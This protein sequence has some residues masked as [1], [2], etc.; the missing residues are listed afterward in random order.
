MIL[1][2]PRTRP[3]FPLV[4]LLFVACSRGGCGG[5]GTGNGV[6]AIRFLSAEERDPRPL[7]GLLGATFANQGDLDA[8][9]HVDLA[10]QA[11]TGVAQLFWGPL[12]PGRPEVG[13]LPLGVIGE[14]GA[15]LDLDR[16]GDLD[17]LLPVADPVPFGVFL[18]TAPRQFVR[19]PDPVLPTR[20]V[21]ALQVADVDGDGI[22]DVVA[23]CTTR[24]LVL[25]GDGFGG[26]VDASARLP[27]DLRESLTVA[28][29]ELVGGPGADL[30]FGG[31]D[32]LVILRNDGA[33]FA[34]VTAATVAAV[35]GATAVDVARIGDADADGFGD[36][37]LGGS[38][39]V[40]WLRMSGAGA[41]SV[42]QTFSSLVRDIAVADREGDGDLDVAVARGSFGTSLFD[43]DRTTMMFVDAGVL[44][45]SIASSSTPRIGVFADLDD[46]GWSDLVAM[47]TVSALWGV[48]GLATMVRDNGIGLPEYTP[49]FAGVGGA[50]ALDIERDGDIDLFMAASG[51]SFSYS[52]LL[53]NDG[54]GGFTSEPWPFDLPRS[55]V[56]VDAD[57][58][59]DLLYASVWSKGDGAGN[60]AGQVSWPGGAAFRYSGDFDGDGVVE[61]LVVGAG[62]ATVLEPAPSGP[63]PST[64]LLTGSAAVVA[65]GNLDG[66][67][68]DDLVVRSDDLL[69]LFLGQR[70]GG[71]VDAS[72]LVPT[73]PEPA[74]PVVLADW[75]GDG[76]HDL[77]V[78]R[79]VYPASSVY[80]RL[81]RN[82]G[83]SGFAL[84][85][86][87]ESLEAVPVSVDSLVAADVDEDG[88]DEVFVLVRTV[89]LT[90]NPDVGR[91][92]LF[93]AVDASGAVRAVP[94]DAAGL[95]GAAPFAGNHSPTGSH[96]PQ[97][98]DI[99]GDAD[100]DLLGARTRIN[101]LRDLTTQPRSRWGQS[102]AVTIIDRAAQHATTAVVYL[103]VT[104]TNSVVPGLGTVLVDPSAAILAVVDLD[105]G[106]GVATFQ[107]PA[108]TLPGV[109]PLYAQAM[110]L[111]GGGNV[112][113]VTSRGRALVW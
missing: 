4:V 108:I 96:L 33:A 66:D 56:D 47:G 111:D 35:V 105:D 83:P 65:S 92:E 18:Q 45:S 67:G 52:S 87:L 27:L 84:A 12:Q 1:E 21:R 58:I 106:E 59:G 41:L 85:G 26:L 110:L 10:L 109:L 79:A 5:G 53:R 93:E 36:L 31:P 100:L 107:L 24:N 95:V 97:F 61:V 90:H 94:I 98:A 3:V 55:I 64:T 72:A 77:I 102:L 2:M 112:H 69:L 70:G 78:G 88:R 99:D 103:G 50:V 25:L 49:G 62:R 104:P 51:T 39:G 73:L 15:V 60:Y 23:A 28:V 11:T 54:S 68:I 22:D 82:D 43:F 14:F 80:A 37:L 7:D 8:D 9:G 91:L 38:G 13:E 46:N 74:G 29:G 89:V 81:L 40:H 75:D 32:G 63:Q 57:G 44:P 42:A 20:T 86:V 19:Q 34:D 76:D 30:V 48:P 6:D 17:L 16:D 113:H 71:F 101:G